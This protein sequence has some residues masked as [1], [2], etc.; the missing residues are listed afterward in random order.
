ML[1]GHDTE[2]VQW[3]G[4][5]LKLEHKNL[6]YL[7]DALKLLSYCKAWEEIIRWYEA[8][9]EEEKKAGKLRYYYISALY[10]IGKAK[11]ALELLEENGGLEIPDI[12]EGEDSIAQ[13]YLDIQKTLTGEDV[14]LPFKYD[15]RAT[16]G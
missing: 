14:S 15:F 6:S 4:E 9:D 16:I 3:I 8:F 13:L 2:T 7:K 12:R 10:H 11:E 5:G 1:S